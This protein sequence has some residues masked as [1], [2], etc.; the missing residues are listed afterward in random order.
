MGGVNQKESREDIILNIYRDTGEGNFLNRVCKDK[1]TGVRS[2]LA[3][4]EAHK[5]S[6]FNTTVSS[7]NILTSPSTKEIIQVLSSPLQFNV[8]IHAE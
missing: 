5:S 8:A 3:M 4:N 6:R 7:I 2:P 1:S